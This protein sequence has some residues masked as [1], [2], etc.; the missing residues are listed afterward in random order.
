MFLPLAGV[1]P[2]VPLVCFSV[3]ESLWAWK[4]SKEVLAQ[5]SA[6]QGGQEYLSTG[7][8]GSAFHQTPNIRLTKSKLYLT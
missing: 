7:P 2:S 6:F 8:L 5:K 3:Q 4:N 1:G